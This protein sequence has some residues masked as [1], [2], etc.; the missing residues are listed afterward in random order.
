M[1]V[2]RQQQQRGSAL[3]IIAVFALL[4]LIPSVSANVLVF[5]E[6]DTEATITQD[7]IHIER[8]VTI[9]NNGQSPIIPGELHFRFF[10]EQGDTTQSILVSNVEATSSTG[11]ELNTRSVDRG[12][13]QDVSVQIWNPL[14]PGFEYSFTMSYDIEFETSG[15]LFHEISL[16]REQTTVPIVNEQ[17]RFILEDDYY[18]TYAP[19]TEVNQITGNSVVE[20]GS[21]TDQRVVEYSRIPFPRTGLRAVNVFWIAIIL[22]LLAVF[23]LGFLRQRSEPRKKRPVNQGPSQQY[24]QPY[25][26][27]SQQ[28][29]YGGQ[30]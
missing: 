14:L 16:P 2:E 13:E 20:W 21:D 28:G 25:N 4:I 1:I 9:R 11:D 24:Q 19:D 18:V 6:Y 23:M 10:E 5:S 15:I 8:D 22:A 30:R 17:T 27:Q 29:V 12:N 7:R 26:Q 3:T